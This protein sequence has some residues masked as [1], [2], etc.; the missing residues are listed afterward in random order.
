MIL[1]KF[2]HWN[3]LSDK[4][5]G[6]CKKYSLLLVPFRAD[7]MQIKN[8]FNLRG[9]VREMYQVRDGFCFSATSFDWVNILGSYKDQIKANVFTQLLSYNGILIPYTEKKLLPFA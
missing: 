7:P 1:R 8:T 9:H 2:F 3:F 5:C 4:L 6:K